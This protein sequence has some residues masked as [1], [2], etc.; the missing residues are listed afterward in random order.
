MAAIKNAKKKNFELKKFKIKNNRVITD[1]VYLHDE[2]PDSEKREYK[3]VIIP[4]LPHPDLTCLFLQLREYLLREFYIEPSVE[5][6]N[7]VTI[8]SINLSGEDEKLGVII[9]GVLESLHGG[10]LAMNSSRIVFAKDE[11]GLEGEIDVIVDT[12]VDES[13]KYLFEGKRADP[14][15]FQEFEGTEDIQT[16]DAEVIPAKEEKRKGGLNVA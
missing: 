15:L 4:L 16:F 6:I 7:Q 3:G 13:F 9:C 8:T 2:N 12:L 14:T 10:K 1:Y 5:N 11:T